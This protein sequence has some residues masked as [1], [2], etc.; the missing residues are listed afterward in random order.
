MLLQVTSVV[1]WVELH[2]YKV[3]ILSSA[4]LSICPKLTNT[5]AKDLHVQGHHVDLSTSYTEGPGICSVATSD[6]VE[7]TTLEA[8]LACQL[9]SRFSQD[10]HM[11]F[12]SDDLF[13][14]AAS[15][16][17]PGL[18]FTT[19]TVSVESVFKPEYCC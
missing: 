3:V 16:R 13:V 4:G 11:H 7:E 6:F 10:Y 15:L 2:T 12:L 1:S 8:G 5:K 17:L 18:G 14:V 9:T 19:G